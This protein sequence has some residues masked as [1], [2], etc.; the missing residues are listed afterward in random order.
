[1]NL[2]LNCHAEYIKTFLTPETA[3]KLFRLLTK[4]YD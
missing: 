1:M 3:D 4:D 2:R